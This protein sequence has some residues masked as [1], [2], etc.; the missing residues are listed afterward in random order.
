M[1]ILVVG[2]GGREHALTWKLARESRVSQVIAAPGSAG[3]AQE[4]ECVGVRADD[5]EGLARLAAER[6]ADVTMVG[7]EAALAAGIVDRFRGE[8][9]RIVG[10]DRAGAQLEASKAFMKEILSEAGVPTAAYRECTDAA[11]ARAFARELGA[12]LVVKADGLAAGKGVVV[13]ATLAQADEAIADM[14][15]RDRFGA[16]GRKVVVE[17]FLAG[18][19][20]SFIVFTDGKRVLPLAPSQDHKAVF[21]DDRGPNTGG[22]GAY[23]PAP[24]VDAELADHVVTRLVQPTVDALRARGIDYRGVL[25]AGLMITAA[26]PKVL[27]Y[28][29]RFGDPETQP[30][31]MRMRSN[32]SDVLDGCADGD[33]SGLRVEWDPGA[34]VC[35]VMAAAGYPGEPAKGHVITGIE[36]AERDTAVKVFHAGTRR[37][38]EGRWLSDGGR[39]LGVTAAGNDI[40]GAIAR[41]YTAVSEISWEGVHYR[42]DIGRKALERS[43]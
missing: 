33:L 26:G 24:V 6:G 31:M 34:A 8:G 38:A 5:V 28:N 14:L 11:A 2:S 29:V 17:E 32:L 4:A 20:A 22:M 40:S 25:Y 35:V 1:K 18:E 27:E 37:D 9:L 16:A 12:P 43:R 13:C 23:S 7:P 39:V 41:V 30:L 3:I 19:E 42:R 21:D 36:S 15:E 10:P